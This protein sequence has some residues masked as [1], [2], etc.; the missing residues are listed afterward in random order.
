[1]EKHEKSELLSIQSKDLEEMLKAIQ[2]EGAMIDDH[3]S[4]IIG[5]REKRVRTEEVHKNN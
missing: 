3:G 4:M 2:K 5:S 1:M